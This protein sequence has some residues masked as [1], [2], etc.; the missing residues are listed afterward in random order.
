[1]KN[2]LTYPEVK[3]RVDAG[4][5]SLRGWYYKIKTGELEYFNDKDREFLPMS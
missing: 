3:S 1:M 4:K 5:L 2:L